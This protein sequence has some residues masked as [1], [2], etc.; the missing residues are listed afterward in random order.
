MEIN[1]SEYYFKKIITKLE[2]VLVN[3][4]SGGGTSLKVVSSYVA[5]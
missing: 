2:L 1:D 5:N 3:L 4:T